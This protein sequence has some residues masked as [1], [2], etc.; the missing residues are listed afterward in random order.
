[1]INRELYKGYFTQ[2]DMSKWQCPACNSGSLQVIQD[3]FLQEHN[4]ETEINYHEDWFHAPEMITYTFTAL[5]FCTNPRCKEV[6]TCSGTGCVEREQDSHEDSR[7][8]EY[9]KPFF[10]YPSLNIFQIPEKTPEK[11]KQSIRGSFSLLFK[12]SSAAANKIRSAL[13]CLLIKIDRK[14]ANEMTLHRR[15][16]LLGEEHQKIKDFCLAVKW[17]GNAG[18]HCNDNMTIDDVFDGYDILSFILEELYDNKHEK[19]TAMAETIN[20]NRGVR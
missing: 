3:K 2:D 1:M 13:E 16:E 6:V 5:L 12:S 20:E 7:Y 18:S 15:I 17:L 19:L 11:V 14:Q 10:F 4:S 9:F 8:I